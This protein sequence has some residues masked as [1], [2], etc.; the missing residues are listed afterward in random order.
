M[1]SAANDGLTIFPIGHFATKLPWVWDAC[2]HRH[3]KLSYKEI[4]FPLDVFMVC[5]VILY[6][7]AEG[8]GEKEI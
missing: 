3:F 4:L 6:E 5:F 1:G 8:L 7:C 2:R